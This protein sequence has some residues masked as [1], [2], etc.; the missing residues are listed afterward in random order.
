MQRVNSQ[1]SASRLNSAERNLQS[2]QQHL[3][4]MSAILENLLARPVIKRMPKPGLKN[5]P[6]FSVWRS[7]LVTGKRPEPNRTRTDQNRKSDGPV[8]TEN[9]GPVYGPSQFRNMKKDQFRPVFSVSK[10]SYGK[11]VI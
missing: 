4:N 3:P 10:E 2:E 6:T 8:E 9:R 1:I 11:V 7:G 5:A